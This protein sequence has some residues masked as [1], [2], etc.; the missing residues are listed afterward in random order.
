MKLNLTARAVLLALSSSALI[1]P[2]VLAE[3]VER[4][5]ETIKALTFSRYGVHQ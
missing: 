3:Q 1:T 4:G 5:I 2:T